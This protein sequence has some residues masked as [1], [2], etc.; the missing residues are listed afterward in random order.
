M[1]REVPEEAFARLRALGESAAKL[2]NCALT[3]AP[4]VIV[5]SAET[6][7]VQLSAA[8]FMPSLLP[9][10][11]RVKIVSARSTYEAAYGEGASPL[12]WKVF[13]FGNEVHD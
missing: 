3:F 8:R 11:A 13:A 5:T 6:G 10:L 7:W 9:I 2:L 1:D 4:V 12:D